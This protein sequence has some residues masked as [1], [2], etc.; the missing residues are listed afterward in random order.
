MPA[1]TRRSPCKRAKAYVLVALCVV[2][3]PIVDAMALETKRS[4]PCSNPTST[5]ITPPGH[6]FPDTTPGVQ[7]SI[8]SMNVLAPA[9]HFLGNDDDTAEQQDRLVRVP[10]AI[11][12]AKRTNADILMLQEAEGREH[13]HL[14][15]RCLQ[16]PI[17]MSH[18]TIPGYDCHV[19]SALYPNRDDDVVGCAVAW[20]S[21]RFRLVSQESYRRGMVVQLQDEQGNN[22]VVANLHLFAKPSA[23][24]QRLKAMAGTI[25]RIQ[26]LELMPNSSSS[27]LDG[28]VV[29]GGDLNCDHPSVTT[30]LAT[31]GYS[32]YG[33]LQDRNYATRITKAT[34][35]GMRHSYRFR[36]VYEGHVASAAPVTVS[37][38]GR[39]PGTMDHLFYI[40]GRD[41]AKQKP[42]RRAPGTSIPL[43]TAGSKRKTRRLRA[44]ARER[45][46]MHGTVQQKHERQ[47]LCV[48]A[49]LATVDPE[50][51][52][53]VNA[54]LPNVGKGFPSDHLPI[55]AIF[56]PDPAYVAAS[57][58]ESEEASAV[59]PE[60]KTRIQ[61]TKHRHSNLS[62]RAFQRR[63]AS[64]RST[65]V[66]QRHNA[67]LR[68][69][70]E[71]LLTNGAT[72]LLRDRPLY[73]WPWLT[74]PNSTY[75]NKMRAPDL[76]F[77]MQDTL[78]IVEVAV[79]A[80]VDKVR[81]EKLRKYDD[82]VPLLAQAPAVLE[83]K[84]EVA[85]VIVL[86][87]ETS[88]R[89]PESTVQDIERLTT[90]VSSDP[91]KRAQITASLL[92][93]LD[94]LVVHP[95]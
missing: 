53:I 26:S 44:I 39:G 19:W 1:A 85:P 50:L 82:I 88:G 37:L 47:P 24:E 22:I 73:Q 71:W 93:S 78:W 13:E 57:A 55:G 91:N 6:C 23:I 59:I 67:V 52:P 70:A 36:H 17:V 18:R 83:R 81:K 34:A 54:G 20:R 25:R 69:V 72:D 77:V 46:R 86:A 94:A 16:E 80:G 66:L 35:A 62:S 74:S 30:R 51:L 63:R 28:L 45:S 64:T 84:L 31:T 3:L 42:L 79:R 8:V 41:R 15:K 2:Q 9:Y 7:V 10:L 48:Q 32:P 11:A 89:V 87:L 27:P 43:A 92:A 75:R 65:I 95:K 38:E 61:P 14:L 12:Q 5:T 49:L 33:R 68:T 29:L 56:G 58:S 4:A 40:S 60:P 76:C 90:G 21:D